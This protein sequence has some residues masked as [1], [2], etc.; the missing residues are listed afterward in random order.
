MCSSD[1]IERCRAP[2]VGYQ[3]EAEYRRMI[4][5]VVVFLEGKTVDVRIR[6]RERMQ[7]ASQQRDF[8]RAA[9]LR[10]ALKW[11]DQ[12]EQPQAVEL[13]GR[14]DADAVGLARDGDDVCGVVLRVRDGKLIARDHWFLENAEHET[15]G[16]I[17]AAFL[18]RCYLPLEE[19]GRAHV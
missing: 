6:L 7:Q 8:E 11:L 13:I 3:S 4:D 19:I 15:E 1:L 9:Q 16:S 2:C 18:V 10:D 5:D 17:L 12:L 14:G